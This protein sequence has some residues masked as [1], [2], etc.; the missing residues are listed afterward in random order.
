LALRVPHGRRLR[1]GT[2]DRL[3]QGDG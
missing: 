2:G 3:G 1:S